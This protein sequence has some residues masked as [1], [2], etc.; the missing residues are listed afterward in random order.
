MY[1]YMHVWIYGLLV[2]ELQ[3]ITLIFIWMLKVSQIS[4][5]EPLQGDFCAF[6]Y[7][8]IIL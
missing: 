5:Q 7:V 4:Q 8:L 6:L 3:P 1:V 2:I